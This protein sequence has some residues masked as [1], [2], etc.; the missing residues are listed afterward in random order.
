MT[1]RTPKLTLS[2]QWDTAGQERFRSIATSYYRG[3]HGIILAYDV[4][5][6]NSFNQ[7]G[8]HL[9]E[10][11]RYCTETVATMLVGNKNDLVTSRQVLTSGAQEFADEHGLAF[12]ETSA[13]KGTNVESAFIKMAQICMM[14]TATTTKLQEQSLQSSL[15]DRVTI[16]I[17]NLGG[18][19]AS[20]KEHCCW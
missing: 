7:L 5:D 4:T 19:A 1:T 18:S 11:E 6:V 10:I 9:C 14:Q 8:E 15:S 17:S 3:A 13:K 20:I 16:N 2:H 12:L